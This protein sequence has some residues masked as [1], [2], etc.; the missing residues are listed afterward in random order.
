MNLLHLVSDQTVQN[1]L[2]VLALR[3]A[4]VIQV[5]SANERFARA[6]ERLKRAVEVMARKPGYHGYMPEFFDVVIGSPEPDVDE[7]R[8]KVGEALSLWPGSVVN[9]TGGTKMMAIGAYLAAE[10]QQEP[11]LYCDTAAR[12]FVCPHPMRKLPEM[13]PFDEI[14]ALL[15]LDSLFAAHGLD[16]ER[17]KI[18][19]PSDAELTFGRAVGQLHQEAPEAIEQLGSRLRRQLNPGGRKAPKSKIDGILEEGLPD[20]TT[21][22]EHRFFAAAES[23]GYLEAREGRYFYAIPDT[24]ETTK[25]RL[26]AAEKINKALVGGWY[27]LLVFDRMKNSGKFADLGCAVQS[28]D[29]SSRAL[30]ENDIVAVDKARLSL[31]FVSCKVSDAH[32]SP[33]E[34]VFSIQRRAQEFGGSFARSVFCVGHFEKEGKREMMQQACRALRVDWYEGIPDFITPSGSSYVPP[35]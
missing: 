29:T 24:A 35:A 26:Y 6:S 9:V 5:R 28:R 3:P 25:R 15:T 17:L 33:L 8:R 16:P 18:E 22:L 34:H 27:E 20:P 19:I 21:P 32:M 1:L 13:I 4:G 30:G 2:P 7:T 23:A 14:A 31:V 11:V 10:Y 12:Q